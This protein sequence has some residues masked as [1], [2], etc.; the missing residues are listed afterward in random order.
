MMKALGQD[1]IFQKIRRLLWGRVKLTEGGSSPDSNET[2]SWAGWFAQ[3][4]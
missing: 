2:F 1:Q 3:T 4:A